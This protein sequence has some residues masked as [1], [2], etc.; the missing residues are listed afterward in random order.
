MILV[1]TL[2]PAFMLKAGGADDHGGLAKFATVVGED[3]QKAVRLTSTSPLWDERIIW[4]T[5]SV[6]RLRWQFPTLEDVAEFA[7]PIVAAASEGRFCPLIFDV[8]TCGEHQLDCKLLC[9]GMGYVDVVE[10]KRTGRRVER[11]LCLPMCRRGGSPYWSPGDECVVREFLK[12]LLGS[13]WIEKCCHNGAFDTVVMWAHG[14]PVN[15]WT[16]DTMQAHHVLDAELPQNLGFV[17]SRYTDNRYWKDDVKGGDGWLDMDEGIL[18]S[19]NLRDILVTMRVLPPL[20]ASVEME[21]LGALYRNELQLAQIMARATIRGIAVDY[22]RRDSEKLD[23]NGKPIGLA[24]Q[25]KLQM[26]HAISTLRGIGGSSFDPAKPA[27][28]RWLLFDKLKLPVVK[29]TASGL[30]ATDKEAL[31]LLDVAADSDEQKHALR[32]LTEFRQAQ[33]FLGTFIEGLG[34][35]N[36]T[37]RFH[38]SWKL[39]PVTG[40]FGSSPNAQNLP[41]RV[42]KIFYAPKG[43]K[44]VG[45]DLSQAELRLIAYY[46]NEKSLLSMYEKDINVHTV[47]ASMLFRVQCPPEAAD[48]I[49]EATADY[50]RTAVV[51]SLGLKP[52][53]YDA[54]PVVPKKKWKPTRTLAKNYEFGSAYGAEEET[55]YRVLRSKR[56]PDTSDLMF[57]GITLSEVQAL[58]VVWKKL[59]PGVISWWDRISQATKAVGHYKC[60]ISGRVR[61]F[62]GGYQRNEMLNTP[63]QSGVAAWMNKNTVVIQ[64][65]FDRETGGAAQIVQQVHDALTAECPDEYAVRAGQVMQEVLSQTFEIAPGA[66]FERAIG[67]HPEARLPADTPAIATHLDKT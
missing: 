36:K 18:R 38:P 57:P 13:P 42:K 56:D 51:E 49:N 7:G 17:G 11:V 12:L 67:Y 4:E 53:A 39:L 54:F 9:V 40:R 66:G 52:G 28:L 6:G 58:R 59:R 8:E 60:P 23:A 27:Q 45:I 64:E 61:N 19:Y 55:L 35:L 34:V 63:I 32:A 31:M 22:E 37:G 1:P 29:E 26:A 2:H 3:F 65:I 43:W 62:R 21:G 46:A 50:L 15:G 20:L 44:L 48:N 47:N 10:S 24:P 30:A 33:K 16:Q 25:L 14:V 5:D 41:G